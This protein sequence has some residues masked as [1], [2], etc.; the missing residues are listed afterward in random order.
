MFFLSLL[1]LSILLIVIPMFSIFIQTIKNLILFVFFIVVI[2]LSLM[3]SFGL[4]FFPIFFIL[5]YVGAIVVTTLFMILTFDLRAE[6]VKKVFS[7]KALFN[8][9]L[10]F[11]ITPVIYY[12]AVLFPNF[13][14]ND[15]EMDILDKSYLF[16]RCQKTIDLDPVFCNKYF[17]ELGGDRSLYGFIQEQNSDI[18]VISSNL[19]SHYSLLFIIL[20]IILTLALLAALTLVKYDIYRKK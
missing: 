1:F 15:H 5:V 12:T 10:Y 17:G 20:G 14:F 18:A 16:Q 3:L 11:F 4:E 19:Y 7:N 9:F 13:F 6:Y 2:S 8:V